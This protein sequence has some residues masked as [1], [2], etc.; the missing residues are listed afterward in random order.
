MKT[1]FSKLIAHSSRLKAK[2]ISNQLT[3][4][5]F[6]LLLS[7]MSCFAADVTLAWDANTES[8]LAGYKVFKRE[9]G[10]AY[11]YSTPAW[12]GTTTTCTITTPDGPHECYFVARA[13]DACGNESGNSNEV[14]WDTKPPE[15][16][17]MHTDSPNLCKADINKDGAVTKADKSIFLKVYRAE[18]GRA[19]CFQ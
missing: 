8:D 3:A 12:E 10:Q 5:I 17:A 13:F 14:K 1:L 18:F 6:I 4:M 16:P 9:P 15:N 2:T 19:N 7:A 11:N